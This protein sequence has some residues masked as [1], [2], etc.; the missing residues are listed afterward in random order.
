MLGTD[1]FNFLGGLKIGSFVLNS[2]NESL[3]ALGQSV[4]SNF[5]PFYMTRDIS[6]IFFTKK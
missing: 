2:F 1:I 5:S 3:L 6:R 4:S